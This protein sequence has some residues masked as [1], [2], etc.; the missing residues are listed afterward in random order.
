M[1]QYRATVRQLE[2]LHK[3]HTAAC[4]L[5]APSADMEARQEYLAKREHYHNQQAPIYSTFLMRRRLDSTF[6]DKPVCKLQR[7]VPI[8]KDC[9]VDPSFVTLFRPL[10]AE[11]EQYVEETLGTRMRAWRDQGS[12]PQDKPTR[13]G[14]LRSSLTRLRD[15]RIY[16][17]FP[18]LLRLY[19]EGRLPDL[20][21][22]RPEAVG[23]HM[24]VVQ[25]SNPEI[26]KRSPFYKHILTIARNLTKIDELDAI[27][28]RVLEDR[29]KHPQRVRAVPKNVL[30]FAEVPANTFLVYLYLLRRRARQFDLNLVHRQVPHADRLEMIDAFRAWD[31]ERPVIHI[32]TPRLGGSG[33]DMTRASYIIFVDL[34]LMQRDEDQAIGRVNRPAQT[35]PIEAYVLK[36]TGARVEELIDNRKRMRETL[37]R[38]QK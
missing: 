17:V 35:M 36:A 8:T 34:T 28:D 19:G 6:L 32:C 31:K 33:I 20:P 29:R 38:S 1:D 10:E 11:F 13:E 4:V 23:E 25:S 7:V 15:Q 16:T 2:G 12:R 26:A 5:M 22:I 18:S 27:L 30:I 37:S 21:P 3:L 9:P 14:V 24:L